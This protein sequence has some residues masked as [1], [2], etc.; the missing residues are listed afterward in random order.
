MMADTEDSCTPHAQTLT[1]PLVC[2]FLSQSEDFKCKSAFIRLAS[3]GQERKMQKYNTELKSIK[4]TKNN[5]RE[6]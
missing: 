1:N 5:P 4:L 2:V 3:K 6:M